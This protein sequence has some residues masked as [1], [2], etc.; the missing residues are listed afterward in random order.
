MCDGMF[1][2]TWFL[3]FGQKLYF[4]WVS[5]YGILG[6]IFGLLK[7]VIAILFGFRDPK[8]ET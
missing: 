7:W 5:Y 8:S 3:R 4:V 2:R 6:P 1:V